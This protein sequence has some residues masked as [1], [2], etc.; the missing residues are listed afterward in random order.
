[1]S[2]ARPHP[3]TDLPGGTRTEVCGD[4]RVEV[5][6]LE[7][8]DGGRC[9]LTRMVSDPGG[10]P[11]ILLPGMFDTR[12]IWLSTTGRGLAVSLA[13][14]G[15]SPWVLERR[16]AARSGQGDARAG[17]QEAVDYDLPLAQRVVAQHSPVPAFWV[18]HSF[19]GV[20]LTRALGETL[21]PQQV[22]GVVLVASA[23]DSPL[24]V[25]PIVATVVKALSARGRFPARRLRLG[26]IDEPGE[27]M[28]DALAWALEQRTGIDRAPSSLDVPLLALTGTRDLIAPRRRCVDLA[29]TYATDRRLVQPAG[30]RHGFRRSY[31]HEG[32]LLHP[33]ARDDVF[34][35]IIDW[36]RGHGHPGAATVERV[37]LPGRTPKHRLELTAEVNA[38]PEVVF[39]LLS[40][41]W[42]RL[43]PVRQDRARDGIDPL[44][45]NGLRS[46]RRQRLLP[47]MTLFEEITEHVVPISI[48]YTT[49]DNPGVCNHS[50]RIEI[51]RTASGSRIDYLMQ[52]D[53]RP[54]APGR[55]LRAALA[56]IWQH[57]SVPQLKRMASG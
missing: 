30:R 16:T 15:F 36:L 24:L 42:G 10:T 33:A 37:D 22:A 25:S 11:V 56:L 32:M 50:G 29:R 48:G 3:D 41:Q 20:V 54:C 34:P 21:D 55:L 19:G 45:P 44:V 23:T 35:F 7:A 12:R 46:V 28:R 26:P 2:T 18:G 38:T 17:W 4:V 51:V 40:N 14:A 43:W 13:E 1:M 47:G 52:F 9:R 31:G 53:T 5:H 49:L 6:T 57:W 27:A 8:S 39:D